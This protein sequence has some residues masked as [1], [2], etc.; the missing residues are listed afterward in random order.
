MN[1]KEHEKILADLH[2]LISSQN[3]KSEKEM[4][5][6]LNSLIGKPLP[7]LS[8]EQLTKEEQA[9]DLV[10]E[11][12]ELPPG[13]AKMKARE[14]LKL[15]PNCIEAFELLGDLEKYIDKAVPFYQK[16]IE[17]GKRKFG[18][19][20]L[21]ENKGHFWGIYETRPYMRCLYKL[22]DCLSVIG[23]KEMC[24]SLLEEMIELNPNDNQG[25][26]HQLMLYLIE[27]NQLEK[28]KK[29]DKAYKD[30]HS[31]Y[32]FFNR[33]LYAFRSSGNSAASNKA[34]TKALKQNKFVADLLLSPHP[35]SSIPEMYQ[36]G[37]ENEA[38]YY[39]FYAYPV[40]RKIPGAL[41]WLK[42]QTGRIENQGTLP[43]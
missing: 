38:T 7:E 15:D 25:V 37:D 11:A 16:A 35:P 24:V 31:V 21:E 2:R 14:A 27:L 26:R 12:E 28:F 34:L 6:F 13:K 33:A 20:F 22:A 4:K 32:T 30:E 3:F 23:D 10:F 18:G 19:K 29:Y 36:E 42:K 5:D 17:I 40:W 9:Q 1:K 8:K 39:A 43:L 41:A